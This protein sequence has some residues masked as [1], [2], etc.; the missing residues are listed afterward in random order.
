MELDK[1]ND[2]KQLLRNLRGTHAA[3]KLRQ[4]VELLLKEQRVINESESADDN[5]ATMI[6]AIKAVNDVLFGENT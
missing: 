6:K 5:S 3:E 1:S 2:A 4:A